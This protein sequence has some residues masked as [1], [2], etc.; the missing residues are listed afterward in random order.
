MREPSKEL[1]LTFNMP[2]VI[3]VAGRFIYEIQNHGVFNLLNLYELPSPRLIIAPTQPVPHQCPNIEQV[4]IDQVQNL[5]MS[6]HAYTYV[7]SL[8]CT[9][10]RLDSRGIVSISK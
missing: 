5:L 7:R 8:P 9:Q 4:S 6:I 1:T 3:G 10:P 2:V